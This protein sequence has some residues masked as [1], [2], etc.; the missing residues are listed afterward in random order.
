MLRGARVL[1][2]AVRPG[3][4]LRVRVELERWRGRREVRDVLVSVPEELPD[5]RYQLMVGGGLEVSRYEASKLPGR[6]RPSTLDEAWRRFAAL[7]SGDTLYAVLFAKAPEVTSDGRDYPE[8]PLSAYA[9]LAGPQTGGDR[10]RRGELAVLGERAVAL[11]GAVRGELMLQVTV[12][13]RTP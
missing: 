11:D 3:G 12:D 6:Y 4:Q 7:R 10:I 8:L 13:S 2:A 9:L 1:D 5:G